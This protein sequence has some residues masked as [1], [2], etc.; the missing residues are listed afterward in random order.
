MSGGMHWNDGILGYAKKPS[1]ST[2][3]AMWNLIS[4]VWDFVGWN[5][6]RSPCIRLGSTESLG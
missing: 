1:V 2:Q 6:A 5:G 4:I 3:R